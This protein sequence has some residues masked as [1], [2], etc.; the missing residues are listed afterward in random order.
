MMGEY[1]DIDGELPSA[2]VKIAMAAMAHGNSGFTMI[3]SLKMM[4]FQ[5]VMSFAILGTANIGQ[6]SEDSP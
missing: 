2:Y 4:I 1:W 3:Y 5:F 6:T